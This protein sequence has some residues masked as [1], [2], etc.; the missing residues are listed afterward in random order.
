MANSSL[1]AAKDAKNDEFYTRLEDINKEMNHYEDKFRGK[2]VFCNCDDPKWSNFWKYFHSEFERL[3]LKKLI[4]T[5]LESDNSQSYKIEYIGGN[6]TD[7]EYGI[8]TPLQ[9]NGDFR[10]DECITL[11]DEADIVVTNPPFSL[12]REYVAALIDHNKKFIII[13]NKNAVKY[14]EFFP[15]LKNDKIWIGYESPSEFNTPTGMTKKVQGLCRWFTNLDIAKR[16]DILETTYLYSKEEYA[17]FDELKDVINVN[18]VNEIP[19]DYDGIMAVPIT[20]M[21]K[22]N[23]EQF[24]ILDMLNRYTVLDYFGVNENVKSRHSHCCNI[25]GNPTFSRVVIRK[26]AGANSS[27]SEFYL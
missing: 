26:K 25:G 27:N 1:H 7:F 11:L 17:T 12:F 19:I 15:Y 6:D 8:I 22:Y 10:S 13:G 23:P 16:H 9:G 4:A 2:V 24:E 5:H 14:K 18:R 21:D 20:F 3:G